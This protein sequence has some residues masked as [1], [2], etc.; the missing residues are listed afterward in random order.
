[1]ADFH[2]EGTPGA[3]PASPQI[4]WNVVGNRFEEAEIHG[5][6]GAIDRLADVPVGRIVTVLEGP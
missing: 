1:M 4:F 3:F 6:G 5:S 2:S